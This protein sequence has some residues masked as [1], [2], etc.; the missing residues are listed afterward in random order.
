MRLT[1]LHGGLYLFS[2]TILAAPVITAGAAGAQETAAGTGS[3]PAAQVYDSSATFQ[4]NLPGI[5]TFADPPAGFNPVTATPGQRAQYG[6]PPA[7][8]QAAN[9]NGYA[10]WKKAMTAAS[11]AKHWN[12]QLKTTNLKSMPAKLGTPLSAAPPATEGAPDTTGASYNW[13]GIVNTS[14]VKKFWQRVF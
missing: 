6:F 1:Q 10:L 13:S 4:T 5:R 12:G 3:I 11:H 2:A 14:T 8:D 7:P 9:P